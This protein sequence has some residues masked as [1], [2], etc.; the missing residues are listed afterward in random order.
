MNDSEILSRVRGFLEVNGTELP[1]EAQW[2]K[3]VLLI[4]RDSIPK[5]LGPV[6][7]APARPEN[8]FDKFIGKDKY[9]NVPPHPS[10]YFPTDPNYPGADPHTK[11]PYTLT[12][13]SD[14]ES[15]YSKINVI[16]ASGE[17]LPQDL[18]DL[19]MDAI[20]GNEE[21]L[22]ESAAENIDLAEPGTIRYY[23]PL[24]TKSGFTDLSQVPCLRHVTYDGD[25]K[26]KI[27]S[28][29]ECV[30]SLNGEDCDGDMKEGVPQLE[31]TSARRDVA[32]IFSRVK[33]VLHNYDREEESGDRNFIFSLYSTSLPEE[34]PLNIGVLLYGNED[35]AG[36]AVVYPNPNSNKAVSENIRGLHE[37]IVVEAYSDYNN[38]IGKIL[39][40]LASEPLLVYALVGDHPLGRDILGIRSKAKMKELIDNAL[41]DTTEEE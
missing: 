37:D 1:T 30:Y 27:L 8:P 16:N 26:A 23:T 29:E 33:M 24:S 32:E 9:P 36:E 15:S 40:H 10:P 19:V 14:T 18:L 39:L 22:A 11:P 6:E 2:N 21:Y 38:L 7:A 17:D 41:K 31:E 28:I 25:L 13:S 3:L 35:T 34:Y 5:K 20:Q 4:N 12:C